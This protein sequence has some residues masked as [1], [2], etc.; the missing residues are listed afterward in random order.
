MEETIV[1]LTLLGQ[2]TLTNNNYGC[3]S[4]KYAKSGD[5]GWIGR[6]D[7]PRHPGYTI[8]YNEGENGLFDYVLW[9]AAF[10]VAADNEKVGASPFFVCCSTAIFLPNWNL[11]QSLMKCTVPI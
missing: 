1:T 4:L 9:E 8:K 11:I 10:K 7:G 5:V 6:F 3:Y 2:F